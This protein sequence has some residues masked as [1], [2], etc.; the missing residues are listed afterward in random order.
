MSMSPLSSPTAPAG[1]AADVCP[2]CQKPLI[3]PGGLGWCQAC[4]YCRSVA[5]SEKKTAVLPAPETQ[6][7]KPDPL[8]ATGSAVSQ[9]P[10]WVWVT[11]VGIVLIAVATFACEHVLRFE[12]FQRALVTT[13]QIVAG[14]G[15]MFLGQL[16]GLLRIAPEESSVTF[17][18]VL[19]PFRLYGLVFKRL[20]TT[21][22]TIYLGAWGLT[23][24]I[25]AGI[26]IGG[27][28]FWFTYLPGHPKNVAA[29]KAAK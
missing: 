9:T 5:E 25:T 10:T 3:D 8:I 29:K 1:A 22:H 16:I 12:P 19:F 23:A 7:A 13:L 17:L 15:L 6:P 14:I 27:L 20:P 26:F 11:L 28:D 21:R 4:G 2:R 18:D 24:A